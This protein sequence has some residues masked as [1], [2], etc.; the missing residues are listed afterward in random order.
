VALSNVRNRRAG[1]VYVG[2]AT[3]NEDGDWVGR[4]WSGCKQ[5]D[6]VILRY[7]AG[8][9]PSEVD[10]IVPR[11]G[12]WQD[13]LF[14][15]SIAEMEGCF[16]TDHRANQILAEWQVDMAVSVP[17]QQSIAISQE[18]MNSP[19]GTRRGAIYAW[20]QIKHLR[21]ARGKLI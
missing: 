14:R 5:P 12:N 19:L 1:E 13:I 3:V 10:E 8:A 6:K 11:S 20:N 21:L 18:Q 7:R 16:C 15:L 17:K 9:R 2:E 4:N